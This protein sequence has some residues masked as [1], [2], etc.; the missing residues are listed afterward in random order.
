MVWAL[1]FVFPI[2]VVTQ[3]ATAYA[4]SEATKDAP[5]FYAGTITS[6]VS[7]I[8]VEQS[9][10]IIREFQSYDPATDRWSKI[11]EFD[12]VE[13]L[14]EDTTKQQEDRSLYS[15]WAYD[16]TKRCWQKIDIRDYGHVSKKLPTN[17]PGEAAN[18]D[19]PL[20]K[21]AG[22]G[23][24]WTLDLRVGAGPTIYRNKLNNLS[25]IRIG[26]DLFLK[27]SNRGN[28][29]KSFK[30]NWFR[31]SY[32]RVEDPLDDNS[33]VL[34]VY[35][36]QALSKQFIFEGLG[37]NIPTIMLFTHY[38]LCK[39]IR[40]G[41]GCELAINQLRELK[42]QGGVSGISGFNIRPQWFYNLAWVGLLGVKAVHC[43]H[44]DVVFEL[45]VGRNYNLGPNMNNLV[46][47]LQYVYDGWLL[48]GGVAYERKLNNQFRFLVRIGSDWK[49][50][51]DT[52]QSISNVK[53][54]I[55]LRQIAFHLDLGLQL[56][57]GKEAEADKN[58][59]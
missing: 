58:I 48:G 46:E 5:K 51:D 44:Q 11:E 9:F 41:V 4:V 26:Q 49:E 7:I 56:S 1:F 42:L 2:Q 31:S 12:P 30:I 43:P 38:N 27:S 33:G 29:K 52:P 59:L 21:S 24:H 18:V 6:S 34:N 16:I 20:S 47:K 13:L 22:F 40:L 50:H 57:L 28:D 37:W 53:T 25:L 14:G 15:F 39:R 8:S 35:E 17:Q 19:E 55:V 23:E 32:S 3:D 54:S 45:Q 36:T 10:N